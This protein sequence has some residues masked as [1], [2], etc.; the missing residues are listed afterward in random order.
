MSAA[1]LPHEG[2]LP[3]DLVKE[4]RQAK[5]AKAAAIRNL[6]TAKTESARRAPLTALFRLRRLENSIGQEYDLS[7]TP[8]GNVA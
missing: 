7:L 2:T 1:S 8:K 3:A 4:I 5:A 6:E